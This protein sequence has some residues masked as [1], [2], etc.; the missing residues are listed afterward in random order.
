MLSRGIVVRVC[1]N[2]ACGLVALLVVG[3]AHRRPS[4]SISMPIVISA[5]TL[6]PRCGRIVHV[7]AE[8]IGW[9]RKKSVLSLED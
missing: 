8:I 6:V 5:L 3:V 1:R 9:G 7:S 2:E 4:G